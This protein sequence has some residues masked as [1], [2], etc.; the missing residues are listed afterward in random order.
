MLL[1]RKASI[2]RENFHQSGTITGTKHFGGFTNF[3][4]S[5]Q[6]HQNVAAPGDLQFVASIGHSV[7]Q[8]LVVCLIG[9]VHRTPANLYGVCSSRNREYRC[10]LAI[11][12]KVLGKTL[13][14][15]RRRCDDD[16]EVFALGKYPLE[17]AQKK[18][19]V[20]GSLVRFVNDDRV[21][22][23]QQGIGL[24]FGQQNAVG[25]QFDGRSRHRLVGKANLIA[26]DFTD[27]AFKFRCDAFSNGTCSNAT[28]LRVSD[29]AFG[30]ASGQKTDFGQLSCL[31]RTGLAA[32][33]DDRIFLNG[34]NQLFS[35]LAHR[36][37]GSKRHRFRNRI[38]RHKR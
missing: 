32:N 1:C 26:H 4:L 19:N 36:Q 7:H 23:L 6:K 5:G 37:A 10:G 30:P 35:V 3:A 33:N 9:I 8:R 11:D 2:Q 15:N 21:V 31:T 24:R 20:D 22:A 14:I 27:F 38:R 28:R 16:F 17:V 25:H 13:R 18:I 34:F 12:F 29:Q